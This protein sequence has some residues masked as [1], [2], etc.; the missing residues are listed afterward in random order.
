M[1]FMERNNTRQFEAGDVI[2]KEKD[3]GSSMFIIQSGEVEVSTTKNHIKVVH[4]KL[5]KGVIFGEMAL[6]DGQPRSATVTAI[7][8]TVCVEI[9]RM[10]FQKHMDELRA[11]F[12][13][14][15]SKI[16]LSKE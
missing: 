4:A 12:I 11:A 5:G 9:S 7:K 8:P 16:D 1:N 3:P 14:V 10:L 2:F 6:I 13:P 15:L